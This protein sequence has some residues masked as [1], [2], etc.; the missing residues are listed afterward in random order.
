M[1]SDPVRF[2]DHIDFD[3]FFVIFDFAS[4]RANSGVKNG[5]FES[6]EGSFVPCP[7]LTQK[8]DPSVAFLQTGFRGIP[9]FEIFRIFPDFYKLLKSGV[10]M[11]PP[12]PFSISGLMSF[13]TFLKKS[14]PLRQK[15][16]KVY[17]CLCSRPSFEG[18]RT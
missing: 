9:F 6:P 4:T 15:I 10:R 11:T 3:T 18:S 14:R 17:F 2:D 12:C 5:S 16:P 8:S 7:D 13:F 1:I